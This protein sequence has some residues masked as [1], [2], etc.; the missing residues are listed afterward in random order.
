VAI[1][2]AV[3]GALGTIATLGGEATLLDPLIS[4]GIWYGLAVGGVAIV[5]AIRRG[6]VAG[7]V[8]QAPAPP[9][10]PSCGRYTAWS[11]R[12]A[13][14]GYAA[15]VH[16]DTNTIACWPGRGGQDGHAGEK[17]GRSDVTWSR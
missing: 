13:D 11:Y 12:P 6:P 15:W 14:V 7:G 5:R 16:M 8:G 1:T 3:V 4:G 17:Y 2:L 9:V 10:C